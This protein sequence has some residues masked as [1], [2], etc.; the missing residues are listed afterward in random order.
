[1]LRFHGHLGKE[2]KVEYPIIS[3][4]EVVKEQGKVD[5]KQ[6]FMLSFPEDKEIF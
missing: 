1:M 6:L 3:S 4:E 2:K 5:G